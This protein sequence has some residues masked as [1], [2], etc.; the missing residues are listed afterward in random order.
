MNLWLKF[1]GKLL[2]ILVIVNL[3]IAAAMSV[4]LTV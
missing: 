2:T 3:S 4:F 1:V